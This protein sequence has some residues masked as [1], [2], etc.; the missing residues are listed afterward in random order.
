MAGLFYFRPL[1]PTFCTAERRRASLVLKDLL[2]CLRVSLFICF[3]SVY[4]SSCQ[5]SVS[6]VGVGDTGGG[7]LVGV[8]VGVVLL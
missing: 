8:G 3:K 7:V 4:C 2:V 1:E 5:C 6:C